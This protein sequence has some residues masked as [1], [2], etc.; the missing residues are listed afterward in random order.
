MII[1]NTV[2]LKDIME[3]DE[4]KDYQWSIERVTTL[5]R[6][7]EYVKMDNKELLMYLRDGTMLVK[8]LL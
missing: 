4:F 6:L 3:A 1:T 8:F 7:L 5:T 2:G